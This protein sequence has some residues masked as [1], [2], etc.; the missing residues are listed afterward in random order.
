ML[1][2]YLILGAIIGSF[3]GEI[4]GWMLPGG[5]V[6]EFFLRHITVGFDP[7]TLDLI[8][9][10]LTFGFSFT[11]NIAG[12]FGLMIAAYLLRWYR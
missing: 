7:T 5:V 6:K 4:I 10:T 8:V 3:L 2:L 1:V 9:F 11:L 12:L